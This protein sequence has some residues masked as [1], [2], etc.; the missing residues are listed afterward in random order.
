[1]GSRSDAPCSGEPSDSADSDVHAAA[2]SSQRLSVPQA[3]AVDTGTYISE[4]HLWCASGKSAEVSWLS[5]ANGAPSHP[6]A[7]RRLTA[8][9][10]PAP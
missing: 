9:H 8:P 10:T 4:L 2:G 1:M 7:P 5:A 3:H 6:C